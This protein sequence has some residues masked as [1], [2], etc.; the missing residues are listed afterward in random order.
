LVAWAGA[1][2]ATVVVEPWVRP[3]GTDIDV[4]M[5]PIAVDVALPDGAATTFLFLLSL[6]VWITSFVMMMLLTNSGKDPPVHV[7]L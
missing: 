4:G 3:A 2:Q 5:K 1:A 7:L 6:W